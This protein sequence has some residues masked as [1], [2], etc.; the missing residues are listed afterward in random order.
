MLTSAA[1]G[2]PDREGAG[3]VV[4]AVAEIGEHV[5]LAWKTAPTRPTA[6]LRRP[7]ASTTW[8]SGPSRPP[9]RGSRSRPSRATLRARGCSC[10]VGSQGQNQGKPLGVGDDAGFERALPS[11]RSPARRASMHAARRRRGRRAASAVAR[12]PSRSA[13]ATGPPSLA[14]ASSRPACGGSIRRRSDRR[15]VRRTSHFPAPA[16]SCA[17]DRGRARP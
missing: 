9:S 7:S 5:L 2:P 15:R 10:C 14:G 12:S 3:M 13:P 11:P 17:R 16:C 4:G 1:I 6:R 8:S